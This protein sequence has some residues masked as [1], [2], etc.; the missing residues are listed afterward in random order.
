[1]ERATTPAAHER[2]QR[3]VVLRGWKGKQDMEASEATEAMAT[4]KDAASE[5][6]NAIVES[7][8]LAGASFGDALRDLRQRYEQRMAPYLPQDRSHLSIVLD[9]PTLVARLRKRHYATT[10]AAWD[11]IEAN[12]RLPERPAACIE[13]A[14]SSLEASED[15]HAALIYRLA[16]DL[17]RAELGD[18]LMEVVFGSPSP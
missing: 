9:I 6:E 16:R 1:V 8:S 18:E 12:I 7:V 2:G 5:S 4:R 3:L 14:A 17:V 13:A 11:E 10:P 15:E